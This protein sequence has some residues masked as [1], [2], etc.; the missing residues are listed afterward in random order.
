MG[1]EVQKINGQWP[2]TKALMSRSARI[3]LAGTL[4]GFM[5]NTAVTLDVLAVAAI[6]I[7][8]KD[9]KQKALGF[10]LPEPFF[11][12]IGFLSERQVCAADYRTSV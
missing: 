5:P 1:A 10:F 12:E 2:I 3:L 11:C 9:K 6:K 4:S 8:F 7:D